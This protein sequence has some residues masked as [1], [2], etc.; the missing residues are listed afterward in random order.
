MSDAEI[1]SQPYM[2]D[3]PATNPSYYAYHNE[4]NWQDQIVRKSYSKN[5]YLKVTGGDN[6]AKYAISLGF[7]NNDGLTKNTDVSR[8]NMRF[9]GDLNLSRR[10]TATTNLSFT[11]SEQNLRDQGNAPVTNP[12]F[13]ALVKAPFLRTNEVSATGIES[14]IIADRDTLNISNPVAITDIGLGLNKAYRFFGSVGFNY[15][16]NKSLRFSVIVLSKLS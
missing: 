10:M 2:Q 9:N 6:I 11:F 7:L 8:Y 15:D 16:I 5:V 3:D 12:L 14:P 13:L 4:T 1:Q